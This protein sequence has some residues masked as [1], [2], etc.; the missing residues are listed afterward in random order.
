VGLTALPASFWGTVNWSSFIP[1][2]I[3]AL[4]TGLTVGLFLF[5]MEQ[6]RHREDQ[7]E[8]AESPWT[9]LS[10]K[11]ES[12]VGYGRH[13]NTARY[14]DVGKVLELPALVENEPIELWHRRLRS[15]DLASLR[16][17]LF[18]LK[19]LESYAYLLERRLAELTSASRLYPSQRETIKSAVRTQT[20]GGTVDFAGQIVE[21]L[22]G[23][24]TAIR[25]DPEFARLESAYVSWRDSVDSEKITLF[26]AIRE[27][28][29][30][31]YQKEVEEAKHWE[32]RRDLLRHPFRTIK[33]EHGNWRAR[34]RYLKAS[35]EE[36]AALS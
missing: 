23:S 18:M 9:I 13:L 1:D 22:D 28:R 25:E 8:Q 34:R 26:N 35:V 20:Y 5:G 17:L 27:R 2:L 3:T 19:Q 32:L 11:V 4:I 33:R 21:D 6:R 14:A 7:R 16:E 12:L 30:E 15:S 24:V 36:T 31:A 10:P 29:S